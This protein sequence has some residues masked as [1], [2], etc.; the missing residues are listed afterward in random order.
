M[1]TIL[2]DNGAIFNNKHMN[3]F[4][5]NLE[6]KKLAS[7]PYV[8]QARGSVEILVKYIRQSFRTSLLD[9][10]LDMAYAIPGIVRIKNHIPIVGKLTPH[11]LFRG[12]GGPSI[13]N[14][15]LEDN[16]K[17]KGGLR[18]IIP[19]NSDLEG[20]L[21]STNIGQIQYYESMYKEI[22]SEAI[23]RQ[24]KLNEGYKK[25]T[26]KMGKYFLVK[27]LAPRVGEEKNRQ[28]YGNFPHICVGK[29]IHNLEL[30]NII[31]GRNI[32]RHISQCKEI[33]PDAKERLALPDDLVQRLNLVSFNSSDFKMEEKEI[34]VGKIVT[35][36]KSVHDE[37]FIYDDDHELQRVS[38]HF[39]LEE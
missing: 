10:Q 25:S 19:T 13:L 24:K 9:N 38:F 16:G 35:R 39:P 18:Q 22:F 28:M 15:Y 33:Y 36:S 27:I 21:K 20:F 12:G 3:T 30:L 4:M 32:R 8:S 14:P 6:I 1:D 2:S 31:D 17:Q 29:N 5:K 7:S 37:D 34:S 23:K 11:H 26:S